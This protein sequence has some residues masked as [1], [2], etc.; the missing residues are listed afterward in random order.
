VYADEHVLK[1]ITSK[2][3]GLFYNLIFVECFAA[4]CFP[5]WRIHFQL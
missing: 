2:E 5:I 1:E 4:C 3:L